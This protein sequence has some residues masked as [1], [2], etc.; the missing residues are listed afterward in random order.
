MNRFF[1]PRGGWP[2]K[3]VFCAA[4]A[5]FISTSSVSA[6]QHPIRIIEE[7]H[8]LQPPPFLRG[9]ATVVVPRTRIIFGDESAMKRRRD[10]AR[11]VTFS[12]KPAVIDGDT[13][14]LACRVLRLFGIDAPRK[15]SEV[16]VFRNGLP[17]W[18]HSD[19][20]PGAINTWPHSRL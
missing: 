13:I 17:M 11:V 1:C 4:V 19:R 12:G 20:S 15:C 10:K 18:R 6:D 9:G 3:L 8:V 16:S 7:S 2:G 5:V 14:R